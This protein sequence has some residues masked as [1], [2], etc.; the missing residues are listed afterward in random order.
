MCYDRPALHK[1]MGN[2]TRS[3]GAEQCRSR[4]LCNDRGGDDSKGLLSTMKEMGYPAGSVIRLYTDSGAA[5]SFV[6]RRGLGKMRHLEIRD[7][8][9]QK[10]VGDGKVIVMKVEGPKNPIDLMTKY[11]KSQGNKG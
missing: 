2:D 7:L 5:K 11:V 10:G 6:S 3:G 4:I 1:D 8:W 9:L